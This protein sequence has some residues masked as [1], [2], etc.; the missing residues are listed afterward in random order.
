MADQ[1]MSLLEIQE[2]VMTQAAKDENFRREMLTDPKGTFAKYSGQ[3]LPDELE[4]KVHEDTKDI[5][6]LVLPPDLSGME[7]SDEDLEKVAGGELVV[8]GAVI[9]FG[10]AA[11]GAATT[12]SVIANDQTRARAGW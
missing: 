1:R 5:L 2:K 8:T 10:V 7:L 9:A 12:G 6:H 3:Q 4:I 11:V